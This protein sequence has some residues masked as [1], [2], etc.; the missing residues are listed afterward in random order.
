[1]AFVLQLA[2]L[3]PIAVRLA[4][5]GGAAYGTVRAGAWE[6]SSG[7][8]DSV[9]QWRHSFNIREIEYPPPPSKEPL[10]DARLRARFA[11]WWNSA[12]KRFFHAF[13]TPTSLTPR[14]SLS[15]RL[16]GSAKPN[17]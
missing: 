13:T 4:V 17:S 6:D 1:M 5:A 16:A 11:F 12:L 8:R 7:S 3:V 15:D 9:E 14:A 10:S 2:R